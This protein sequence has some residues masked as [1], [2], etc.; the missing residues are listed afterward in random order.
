M[1]DRIDPIRAFQR[2]LYSDY[3]GDL[4]LPHTFKYFYGNPVQP[5]V[6]L[7]TALDAVMI[8]GRHPETIYAHVADER[9]VPVGDVPRPF[10]SEIYFDG[11][12]PRFHSSGAQLEEAL[13]LPLNLQRRQ[14]WLTHLVHV[15]LFTRDQVEAYRRLGVIWPEQETRTAFE[16]LAQQSLPWLADEMAVAKP[17]LVLTLGADVA[18]IVQGVTGQAAREALLDG[19]VRELS[20]AGHSRP[21]IHLAEPAQVIPHAAAHTSWPE[22]HAERHLPAVK[23]AL[24]RYLKSY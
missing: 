7:D 21:A 12:R 19:T 9:D 14:C 6:P 10:P 13:L 24:S 11:L 1:T 20:L 18:G 22:I 5:V 3:E 23:Q 2:R 4:Q 8:I 16:E 17:R 15:Y